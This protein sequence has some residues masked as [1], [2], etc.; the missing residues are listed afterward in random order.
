MAHQRPA[1]PHKSK[2]RK[3][4]PRPDK[5]VSQIEKKLAVSRRRAQQLVREAENADGDAKELIRLKIAR[6]K[7]IVERGE[8]E[9]ARFRAG[10]DGRTIP[11]KEFRTGLVLFVTYASAYMRRSSRELANK[12]KIDLVESQTTLESFSDHGFYSG[13]GAWL[14][15]CGPTMKAVMED[16]LEAGDLRFSRGDQRRA[17]CDHMAR[18]AARELLDEYKDELT[19]LAERMCQERIDEASESLKRAASRYLELGGDPAELEE[20]E[21]PTDDD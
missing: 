13:V 1:N 10:D 6:Q 19:D 2:R 15:S 11:V 4:G 12:L 7:Q 16:V 9:L 8:I 21:F 14:T 3:P 5:R 20:D 17:W 18:V